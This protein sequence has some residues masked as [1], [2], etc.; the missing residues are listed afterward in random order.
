M[1]SLNVLVV[2]A[3]IA[4]PATAFFLAKAGATVTVIERFPHLRPGG[5][6]VDIRTTAVSIM[7]KVPGLEPAIRARRAPLTGIS[8]VNDKG[9]V[10]AKLMPTANPDKQNLISEYEIFRGDLSE[11]L[12]D[13]T[14]N[15]ERVKY[16][17]G[18]QVAKI[19]RRNAGTGEGKPLGRL[20]V[21]FA[22]GKLPTTDYD[23]VVACDGAA[24]R[25]R[26]IGFDCDP[27]DNT[28]YANM[29]AAFFTVHK[30]LLQGSTIG[31]GYSTVGGR[32]M[33]VGP[34][35]EGSNRVIFMTVH[36]SKR[37]D[38]AQAFRDAQKQGI[39]ATKQF[40][41]KHYEGAG[42][43]T[44]ELLEEMMT[45]EDFYASDK[46]QVKVPQL[47]RGGVVLVGDAGY[48]TG[49]TGTGTTLAITGAYVLAGE[50]CKH[51]GDLQAGLKGYE[52]RMKP[53]IAD[54]Q[55][56]PPGASSFMAPQT[57]G[58]IWL[59]NQLVTYGSKLIAVI[60][61][62]LSSSMASTDKYKLP[63]YE[64]VE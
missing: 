56:I 24:S 61:P 64:W 49:P 48:A 33:A 50:I 32:F 14:K 43:R 37:T 23:L 38:L 47:S 42:W 10:F 52:E 28:H 63:D 18:E 53:L 25:T 6:N 36:P 1:P 59:R 9:H 21:E 55:K 45:A 27:R 7:R 17:F 35:K 19:T 44:K 58:G 60:G 13:L 15:N 41:A 4:G 34:K 46:V 8:F 31:Q 22:N 3:S 30:D 20:T 16:V 2:G 57:T 51:K 54:M 62:L 29:W 40:L 12:V 39:E 11:V 26:A 5:Q